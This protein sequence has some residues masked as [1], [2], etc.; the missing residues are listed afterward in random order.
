MNFRKRVIGFGLGSLL[1]AVACGPPARTTAGTTTGIPLPSRPREHAALPLCP[2]GYQAGAEPVLAWLRNDAGALSTVWLESREGR[3]VERHRVSAPVVATTEGLWVIRTRPIEAM[4]C[5]I[6]HHCHDPV[7]GFAPPCPRPRL[8]PSEE[9]LALAVMSTKYLS[10]EPVRPTR[11][12]CPEFQLSIWGFDSRIELG[13][14]RGTTVFYQVRRREQWGDSSKNTNTTRALA[15]DLAQRRQISTDP[16]TAPQW[17]AWQ[18]CLGGGKFVGVSP[19]AVE[20]DTATFYR[21]FKTITSQ[22]TRYM[23]V[24]SLYAS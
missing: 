7:L 9:L 8:V 17:N 23:P 15:Y 12:G 5:N 14:T 4:I 10:I 20:G 13:A 3:L 19:L 24:A 1:L 16:P 2:G 11:P 18:E 22:T 21:A 6:A